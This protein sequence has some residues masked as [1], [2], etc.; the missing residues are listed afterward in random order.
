MKKI[1]ILLGILTLMLFASCQPY[2]ADK[3]GVIIENVRLSQN[4]DMGK[5]CYAI[6]GNNDIFFFYSD[7]VY[8]V[9]DRLTLIRK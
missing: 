1:S 8:T 9:G 6:D 4:K 5:Y 7:S 2:C 3:D